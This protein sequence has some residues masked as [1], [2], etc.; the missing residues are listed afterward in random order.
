MSV[1]DFR[2]ADWSRPVRCA[3]SHCVHRRAS[4]HRRIICP[5]DSPVS[6]AIAALQAQQTRRAIGPLGLPKHY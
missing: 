5:N 3:K 2:N 4:R 6:P 1:R